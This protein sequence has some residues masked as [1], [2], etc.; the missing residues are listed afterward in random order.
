MDRDASV[1]LDITYCDSSIY[2]YITFIFWGAEN[3]E[4]DT[5]RLLN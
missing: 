2:I 5:N 3:Y 1:L 4:W